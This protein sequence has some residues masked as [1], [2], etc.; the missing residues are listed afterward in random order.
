MVRHTQPRLTRAGLLAAAL[1][2][3]V[4]TA[5]LAA[6]TSD[7]RDAGK[8]ASRAAPLESSPSGLANRRYTN[9]PAYRGTTH[10]ITVRIDQK[11]EASDRARILRAIHEWN[12]TLNG[13]IRLEV[14]AVPFG[15]AAAVPASATTGSTMTPYNWVI[16]YAPGRGPSRGTRDSIALAVTQP[17]P[18][19]GALMLLYAASVGSADLGNVVL[20]ELGHAFGLGHDPSAL[21]MSANYRGHDQACVDEGTV[22]ALAAINGLP[23]D[24]VS[25]T[26]LTLPTKRI[27]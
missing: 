21:L 19:G 6:P 23:I 26:H 13:Y 3:L 22:K 5:S 1:V 7:E 8:A 25:Y 2:S 18:G 15:V 14:S 10:V 9:R 17:I 20:H 16:A 12:H 24:A 27:V 4:G 11:F